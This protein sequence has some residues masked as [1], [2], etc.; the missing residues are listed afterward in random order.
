MCAR[1]HFFLFIHYFIHYF[2]FVVSGGIIKC[3]SAFGF[4]RKPNINF[5]GSVTL[6]SHISS[7][8]RIDLKSSMPQ[9]SFDREEL[10]VPK[11]VKCKKL[12]SFQEARRLARGHGFSSKEEFLLYD[13][14]GAYQL[15]KNPNVIYQE[16]GWIDWDD[17]L[18]IPYASYEEAKLVVQ[19]DILPQSRLFTKEEYLI[20]MQELSRRKM[21]RAASDEEREA[22][23][24]RLPYRPDI[25]YQNNSWLGWEDYLDVIRETTSEDIMSI[26]N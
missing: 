3:T 14:P 13:C 18:G 1:V 26:T 23:I 10:D 7:I 15:P 17:F 5:V 12:Y 20:F 19:K 22:R 8:S 16:E 4:W 6:V 21:T 11:A 2:S 24:G 9:S 25:Y